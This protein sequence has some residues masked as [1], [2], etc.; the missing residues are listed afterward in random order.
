MKLGNPATGPDFFGRTQELKELWHYLESEHIRFPGV[1]R[2]GK[3]SILKCMEEEAPDHGVLARWLD[4]SNLDSAQGF[5]ARLGEAF[6]EN[7][8]KGFLSKRAQWVADWLKRI[9]KINASIPKALGGGGLGIELDG[10]PPSWQKKADALCLRLHDQPLLF[11]LDEFPVMLKRLIQRDPQEAAQL[12]AWLRIWRQSPGHCRFVFTGSIGLQSLLEQHGLA[13][14]MNDCYSYPLEPFTAK[15]ARGLWLHFAPIANDIPW[16][17]TDEVIDHAFERIGW[18]SPYFLCLLLDAS[19]RA[20]RERLQEAG[21]ADGEGVPCID[22]EDVDDAYENLLAERSRFHHWEKRL[23]EALSADDFTFCSAMLTAVSRS[24]QGLTLRQ[25]S[26]RLAKR[27]A[28]SGR[29]AQRL[30]ELLVRLTD[31][32]Y[33]SSPDSGGRIQFLSFPLRDW[34]HRNHV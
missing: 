13:E 11:L 8:I 22:V 32:G 7:A 29:R 21:I 25:L 1:R 5:I 20:T 34:W 23:K 17:V 31:E 14:L 24:P 27:E 19:M 15:E 6:P 18:L 26:S 10:A 16:Q 12:L 4:L 33:T 28:D 2:L 9:R 30:Q 3:T